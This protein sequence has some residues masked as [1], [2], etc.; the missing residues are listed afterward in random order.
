MAV[1]SGIYVNIPD[2]SREKQGFQEFKLLKSTA[3]AMLYLTIKD[4]KRFLVKTAKTNSEGLQR[5]L[6]REYELSIDCDHPHVA[7]VYTYEEQLPVGAGILMEYID[8]RTLGEYI[9]EGH[10]LRER[11]RLFEELLSAVE[12]L[13]KRGVIH[14]DLKPD[15]ILISHSADRLKLIDFGLADS[16]AEYALRTLGCTPRYASPELQCRGEVDA[17]SDIYSLGVIMSEMFGSSVV[18]R[19]AMN[20]NPTRRY[21]SVE[22][23]RRAWQRPNRHWLWVL[24]NIIVAAVVASVA[25]MV[26]LIETPSVMPTVTPIESVAD[27]DKRVIEEMAVV[28]VQP[29]ATAVQSNIDELLERLEEGVADIGSI[30][31]DSIK[32]ESFREFA[33]RHIQSMWPRCDSLSRVLIAEA[34]TP[35]HRALINATSEHVAWQCYEMLMEQALLLPSVLNDLSREEQEFYLSLI[36][37]GLPYRPF[38]AE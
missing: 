27:D 17:R 30:I 20:T 26:S 11:Q 14:N 13:H 5:L 31:A 22:Q 32:T 15:N 25:Y 3:Y 8:G 6:R 23:M 16:D 10:S 12:Y 38:E 19:R 28:E 4:G 34:T 18:A 2:G 36:N 35:E 29:V 9:A 37:R 33:F 21:S 1:E 24:V 7:H